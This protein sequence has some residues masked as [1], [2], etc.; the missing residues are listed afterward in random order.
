MR[1]PRSCHG[2][3]FE[4][5]SIS[6][7]TTRSP[8]DTFPCATRLIAAVAFPVKTVLCVSQPI[9]EAIRLRAPSNASVASAASG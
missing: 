5:C 6:V 8:F 2:T 7:R 3:M 4:W 1:A 9:H